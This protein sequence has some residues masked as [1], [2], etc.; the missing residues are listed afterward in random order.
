LQTGLSDEELKSIAM[1]SEEEI[2]EGDT[3]IFRE[4]GKAQKLFVLLVGTVDIMMSTD[5]ND[6]YR[7]NLNCTG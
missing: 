2:Y 7:E 5:Q 1:I 4:G 6:S 3:F